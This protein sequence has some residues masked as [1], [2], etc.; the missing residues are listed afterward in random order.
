MAVRFHH[1]LLA[2]ARV[3]VGLSQE[4]AARAGGG[5]V[6]TYRRHESGEGNEAGA[7]AVPRASRRK[8]LEKIS[9]ELGIDET[10][11]LV[12]DDKSVVAPE[13][14]VLPR[15]L[16]FTGRVDLLARLATW[17]DDSRSR[18]RIVCVVAIGGAGKTSLVER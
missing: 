4:D 5:D 6:R 11:L 12:D 16:H 8:L 13:S 18:A 9:R 15:A 10:E 3:E 1:E 2:Q 7:V 17:L 14:A